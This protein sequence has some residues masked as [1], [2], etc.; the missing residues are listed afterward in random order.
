MIEPLVSSVAHS[1]PDQALISLAL[2]PAHPAFAGHFPGRPILPG[3]VQVDW[4]VQL[5]QSYLAS[6]FS[7]ACDFQVKFRRVVTAGEDLFLDLRIDRARR[8]VL[9]SYRVGDAIVSSGRIRVEA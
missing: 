2:P 6:G 5:A 1:G 9:F 4:A 3:V 7:S 8:V